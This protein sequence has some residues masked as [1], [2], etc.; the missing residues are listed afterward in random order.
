MKGSGK[1]VAAEMV[2]TASP[3]LKETTKGIRTG[4][5]HS[6]A[7]SS[8]Y[9]LLTW[10]KTYGLRLETLVIWPLY[11]RL[12]RNTSQEVDVKSAPIPAANLSQQQVFTSPFSIFPP[13][14]PSIHRSFHNLLLVV[15]KER[16]LQPSQ[17]Q[18]TVLFF[19]RSKIRGLIFS[20]YLGLKIS[21]LP[22][23]SSLLYLSM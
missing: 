22:T 13:L 15:K 20:S 6:I 21:H 11:T 17:L 5:I 7:A 3:T 8:Y 4:F 12:H 10:V 16:A 18:T 19:C 9:R 2:Q 1:Q 14:P 23:S